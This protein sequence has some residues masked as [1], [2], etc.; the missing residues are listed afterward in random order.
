MTRRGPIPA[1]GPALASE[2]LRRLTGRERW[3]IRGVLAATA[4][5]AAVVIVAIATAG[6]S[7]GGNCIDFT[8][9]YSFGGQESFQCGARARTTCRSVGHPG[10]FIGPAGAT[11]ATQCRKVGFSVGRAG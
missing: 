9:S 2:R 4:A 3:L 10:G 6:H 8:V 7:T 11:V 1:G 5:L